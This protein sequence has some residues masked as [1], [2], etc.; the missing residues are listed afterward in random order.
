M[1]GTQRSSCVCVAV[2]IGNV[3]LPCGCDS[4]KEIMGAGD[5]KTDALVVGT[6]LLIAVLIIGGKGLR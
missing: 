1:S 2:N 5:W 4:R 3:T 6:V